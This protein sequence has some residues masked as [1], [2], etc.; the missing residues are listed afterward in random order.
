MSNKTIVAISAGLL[1]LGLVGASATPVSATPSP[2]VSSSTGEA[3]SSSSVESIKATDEAQILA[4]FDKYDVPEQTQSEL[5]SKLRAGKP[6][7]SFLPNK[8][9]V[10]TESLGQE[11]GFDKQIQWYEDGSYVVSGVEVPGD[12]GEGGIQPLAGG[13]E[14]CSSVWSNG[15]WKRW[16]NCKV[17][18][19]WTGVITLAFKAEF[20][21]S[22]TTAKI[23][24]ASDRQ[25]SQTCVVASCS[26]PSVW[27]GNAEQTATTAAWAQAQSTVDA[28][29]G[30][31]EVWLQLR[32]NSNG[33]WVEHS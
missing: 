7:D 33:Y 6:L 14:D 29:W 28:A 10:S 23:N 2:V 25:V 8:E 5:I 13:V 26:R 24:W 9:P 32:V 18:N 17:W 20:E 22:S 1:S 15:T 16:N 12:A 4:D 19:S 11:D 30:S 27:V 21:N 3:T 31:W